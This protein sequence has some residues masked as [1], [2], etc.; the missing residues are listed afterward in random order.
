MRI[1]VTACFAAVIVLLLPRQAPAQAPKE[2]DR[3]QKIEKRLDELEK[4]IKLLQA[5]PKKIPLSAL[6]SKIV[7]NWAAARPAKKGLTDLRLEK[8]G[9]CSAVVADGVEFVGR[10]DYELI[11]RRLVLTLNLGNNLSQTF[12]LEILSVSEEE[13]QVRLTTSKDNIRLEKQ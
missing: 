8:E 2:D 11:G 12:E 6:D 7:G 10:G 13:L 4:A 3:I 9:K 1:A 5:P